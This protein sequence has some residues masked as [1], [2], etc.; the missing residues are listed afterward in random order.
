MKNKVV[1]CLH[2]EYPVAQENVAANI[3]RYREYLSNRPSGGRGR[4][5]GGSDRRSR[6][7]RRGRGQDTDNKQFVH[8][9]A[10]HMDNFMTAHNNNNNNGQG[11]AQG[12]N[13]GGRPPAVVNVAQAPPD[14][15]N[16]PDL[17]MTPLVDPQGLL[18]ARIIMVPLKPSTMGAISMPPPTT[19]SMATLIPI[20]ILA[21]DT[22]KPMVEEIQVEED[23]QAAVPTGIRTWNLPLLLWVLKKLGFLYPCY[24][25]LS[26][27]L[28]F[29][30]L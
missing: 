17:G 13:V 2:K 5:R 8:S 3:S 19:I 6:G 7:K 24:P 1:V 22:G 25:P 16:P 12:G 11:V 15:K 29:M 14:N 23:R 30:L 21:V 10:D 9:V 26:K 20:I 28:F 18:Q 27:G 4:G